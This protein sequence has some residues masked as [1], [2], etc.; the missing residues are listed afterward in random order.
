MNERAL[1]R[2]TPAAW[3]TTRRRLLRG[4]GALLAGTAL[5]LLA[6]LGA[7]VPQPQEPWADGTWWSDGTGWVE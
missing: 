4:G 6:G 1:E 5:P 2:T 7:C 3:P